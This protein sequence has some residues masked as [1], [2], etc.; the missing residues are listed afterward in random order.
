MRLQTSID[1][2]APAE[3]VWATLVDFGSYEAWN[4]FVI[5][6]RGAPIVGEAVRLTVNLAGRKMGRTHV[7]SRVEPD[8]T[9][10]WTIQTQAPWWIHGERIQRVERLGPDR[11]RYTNDEQVHGVMGAIVGPL[12]G[13]A[14][15][16]GLEAA[17]RG[18]KAHCERA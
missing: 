16:A 6:V 9:L 2:D 8:T 7:V 11:C 10:A 4:P 15:R 14:V 12:M 18:L 17:G 3:R 13:S 5:R 1:I